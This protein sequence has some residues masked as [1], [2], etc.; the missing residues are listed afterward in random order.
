[1]SSATNTPESLAPTVAGA[2][3]GLGAH[4]ASSVRAT[5]F[6]VAVVLPFV[7]LL[8]LTT[9]HAAEHPAIVVAV[10]AANAVAAVIGHNHTP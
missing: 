9:G 6:W 3:T 1:M 7:V 4:A 5:A 2:V 8:S 10:V